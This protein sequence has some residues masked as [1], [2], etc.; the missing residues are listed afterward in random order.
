[1]RRE[2]LSDHFA[3]A[4]RVGGEQYASGVTVEKARQRCQRLSRAHVEAKLRRRR[5]GEIVARYRA[6]GLARA[7]GEALD[8]NTRMGLQRRAQLERLDERLGRRQ[9]RTLDIVAPILPARAD[10]LPGARERC[11]DRKVAGDDRAGWQVI[12]DVRG[13]LE[14]QR[15]IELDARRRDAFADT[16]IDAHAA[17]VAFKARTKAAPKAAHRLRIECGDRAR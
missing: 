9:Q 4:R 5:G 10:R 7:V 15:Q 14:E 8:E 2:H 6:R 13:R 3:S 11:L 1:M 16:A 12:G 17:D